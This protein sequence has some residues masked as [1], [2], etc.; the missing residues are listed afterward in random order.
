MQF[1]YKNMG[2]H[3]YGSIQNVMYIF[4]YI[5]NKFS[6]NLKISNKTSLIN[7][8]VHQNFNLLSFNDF[9]YIT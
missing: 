1:L 7:S 2:V 8:K 6:E 3:K 9:Q 4:A 5:N